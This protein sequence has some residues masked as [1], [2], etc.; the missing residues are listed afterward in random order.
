MYRLD[1]SAFLVLRFRDIEHS[2]Y[3]RDRDIHCAFPKL[4]SRADPSCVS[5]TDEPAKEGYLDSP[6][7]ESESN[8]TGIGL[9]AAP[10][11]FQKPLGSEFE[12]G[13]IDVFIMRHLPVDSSVPS[14]RAIRRY[15]R[16]TYQ[17]IGRT[18]APFGM[19]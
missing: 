12:W 4:L 1:F 15:R 17:M 6:P 11:L 9:W 2:Y 14:I 13:G 16:M 10:A 7:A 18:R 19:R 3:H 8:C 5:R